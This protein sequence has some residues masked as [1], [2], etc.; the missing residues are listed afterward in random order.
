MV[1]DGMRR[2]TAVKGDAPG[3]TLV[4]RGRVT[5]SMTATARTPGGRSVGTTFASTP[6]IS[7]RLSIQT[8]LSHLGSAPVTTAATGS[9]TRT[10]T[11][12]ETAM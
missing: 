2:M 4:K 7:P 9:V 8:T 1:D 10:I 12:V 6:S 3:T 11:G 5:A